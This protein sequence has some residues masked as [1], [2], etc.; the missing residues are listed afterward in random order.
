ML[1]SAM[2][3]R[4]HP[5]HQRKTTPNT[6]VI[7]GLRRIEPDRNFANYGK[8]GWLGKE[9]LGQRAEINFQHQISVEDD[10]C[11]NHGQKPNSDANSIY[12]RATKF[13]RLYAVKGIP[14]ISAGMK[15]KVADV[16][17]QVGGYR[18]REAGL[19]A[20]SR[21]IFSKNTFTALANP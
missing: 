19:L 6:T 8:E 3:Y 7:A 10:G 1:S 11:S 13:A 16:S 5:I 12:F 14:G 21:D 9:C 20:N 17:P 4:R 15:L 18:A 2:F